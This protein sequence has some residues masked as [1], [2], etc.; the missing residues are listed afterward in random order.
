VVVD[1]LHGPGLQIAD[2]VA[3]EGEV[4]QVVVAREQLLDEL[5]GRQRAPGLLL[6][7]GRASGDLVF[8]F[9]AGHP[10]SFRTF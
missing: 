8:A 6:E 9:V 4:E 7:A 2:V 5:R 3:V 1:Q 10:R